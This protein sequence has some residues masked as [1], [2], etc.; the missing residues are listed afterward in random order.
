MLDRFKVRAAEVSDLPSICEVER[1]SFVNDAYPSF[2]LERLILCC[3]STFF[4]L[5][6][7]EGR[8][9]GYC[10]S[11]NERS[12]AHLISLAVLPAYRGAG[13]ASLLVRE[14][15]TS[16][17]KCDVNE[18]RLE[19]RIDNDPAIQLYQRLGFTKGSVIQ[20]YYSDGS[21]A[22]RMRKFLK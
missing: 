6:D 11:R 19:V 4:V 7:Q 8:V 1:V 15:L 20:G 17:R 3:N 18:V 22:Y 9:V 5:T 14:L 13:I 2:L 21:A 16:L 10:V 12:K